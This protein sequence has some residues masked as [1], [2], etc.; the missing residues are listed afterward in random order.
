MITQT[1]WLLRET[2]RGKFV[3][4]EK[5]GSGEEEEKKKEK[6][7]KRKEKERKGKKGKKG[8]KER[9]KDG[10]KEENLGGVAEFGGLCPRLCVQEL[11]ELL[12]DGRCHFFRGENRSLSRKGE[13]RSRKNERKE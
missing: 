5:K 2:E 1:K 3:E 9:K 10:K 6:K 7:K 11:L 13:V 12:G 4:E 8:K